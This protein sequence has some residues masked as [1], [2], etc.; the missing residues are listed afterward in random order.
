MK[1]KTRKETEKLV[2]NLA[3]DISVSSRK[4]VEKSESV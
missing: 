2:N 1:P 3:Q 4:L